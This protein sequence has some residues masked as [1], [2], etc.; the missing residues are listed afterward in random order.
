MIVR[1]GGLILHMPRIEQV[2]EQ[3]GPS[4]MNSATDSRPGERQSRKLMYC[5]GSR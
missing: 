2:N 3:P 5:S 1:D 4:S